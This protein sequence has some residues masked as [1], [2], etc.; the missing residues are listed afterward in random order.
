M[1]IL[2]LCLLLA[3]NCY[4]LT[5][6]K[7]ADTTFPE[8]KHTGDTP[9]TPS[10]YGLPPTQVVTPAQEL[11]PPS[12]SPLLTQANNFS[13]TLPS[14]KSF[15]PQTATSQG[16][17]PSGVLPKFKEPVISMPDKP[18]EPTSTPTFQNIVRPVG[19]QQSRYAAKNPYH[20]SQ[21]FYTSRVMYAYPQRLDPARTLA[22]ESVRPHVY[23][24]YLPRTTQR[25]PIPTSEVEVIPIDLSK[26]VT[27]D[28]LPT[29][30]AIDPHLQQSLSNGYVP[31]Q[32]S[33][34]PT[35]QPALATQMATSKVQQRRLSTQPY[36]AQA[37]KGRQ[38]PWKR[39]P[40]IARV[41]RPSVEPTL[42]KRTW[43][44]P[45]RRFKR[46]LQRPVK[47]ERKVIYNGTAPLKPA[48]KKP[49]V[50]VKKPVPISKV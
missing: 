37:S 10:N 44:S 41:S 46:E 19:N 38:K 28:Y 30:M 6:A 15:I 47:P 16:N 34:L 11:A 9:T 4:P 48:A 5:P 36:Y 29:Y 20:R 23:P 39:K 35:S 26:K 45:Q 7:P 3:C 22:L 1:K 31:Q 21:G 49:V 43:R 32:I 40:G 24:T 18:A 8:L 12:S 2:F 27:S 17:I 50:A 14:N 13:R 25:V 33:S 42:R